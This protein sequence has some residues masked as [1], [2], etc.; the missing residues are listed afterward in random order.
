MSD[1]WVYRD[2]DILRVSDPESL[3]EL[4][5]LPPGKPLL[6]TVKNP[7]NALLHRLFWLLCYRIAKALGA[8]KDNVAHVLKL[9]TGHYDTIHSEKHGL[10]KVPKSISFAKTTNEEFRDFFNRCVVAICENWGTRR[11]E[12]LAAVED[13]IVPTER[14]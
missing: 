3:E 13:L 7:V 10:M 12:T 1:F 11:K 9:E 14:R 2:G 8:K 4:Q 6:V 5:Q